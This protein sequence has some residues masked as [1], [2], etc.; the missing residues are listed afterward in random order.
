MD[1]G[2]ENDSHEE[3][4]R[5]LC[6]SLSTMCMG[7]NSSPDDKSIMLGPFGFRANVGEFEKTFL[8][9]QDEIG[10]EACG[11]TGGVL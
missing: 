1:S 7:T 8:C 9:D 5:R 2:G 6:C 3:S 11:K 10:D 4:R